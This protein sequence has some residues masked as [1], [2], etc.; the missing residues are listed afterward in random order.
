[1]GQVWMIS[2]D[3]NILVRYFVEDDIAQAQIAA[4]IIKSLSVDEPAFITE[5]VII[6]L[7]WVLERGYKYK[8]A[9]IVSLL[10]LLLATEQFLIENVQFLQTALLRYEKTDK[11]QF[12]DAV[13]AI[14][15]ETMDALPIYSFD[16]NAQALGMTLPDHNR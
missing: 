5:I 8:K 9:D 16:K 15:S 4:T 13:I 11:I 10:K 7:T 1:M 6:E 3:T 2:L 12:A 14:K